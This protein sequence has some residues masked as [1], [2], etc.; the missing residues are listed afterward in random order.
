MVAALCSSLPFAMWMTRRVIASRRLRAI[1]PP[2]VLERRYHGNLEVITDSEHRPLRPIGVTAREVASWTGAL[3]A[4]LTTHPSVRIFHNVRP[5]GASLTSIPHAIS[6]GRKLILIE[7][8]A[9]PPGCYEAAANGHVHCDGTYIGQSVRPLIAS[10]RHWQELLPKNHQVRAMIVVHAA[11]GCS[12][13]LPATTRNLSWV[14]ADGALHD[15][16]QDIQRGHQAVSRNAVAAL[17]AAT[18][19]LA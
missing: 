13:Q 7:S 15:I 8:V 9:W 10:V 5:A 12:V 6:A 16:R 4:D 18:P 1:V 3:L 2:S 17:I 14:L 19:G 11:A